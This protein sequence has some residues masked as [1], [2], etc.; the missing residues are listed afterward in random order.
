MPTKPAIINTFVSP[1]KPPPMTERE[2]RFERE[3]LMSDQRKE[4]ENKKEEHQSKQSGQQSPQTAI[5]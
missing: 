1:P 5:A 2:I 3:G 4:E